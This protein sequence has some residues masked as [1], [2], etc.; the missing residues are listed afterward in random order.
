MHLCIYLFLTYARCYLNLTLH[1]SDLWLISATHCLSSATQ[2]VTHAWVC[3]HLHQSEWVIKSYCS[4]AVCTMQHIQNPWQGSKTAAVNETNMAQR[5]RRE[6]IIYLFIHY[7]SVTHHLYIH[8]YKKDDSSIPFNT[9]YRILHCIMLWFSQK[10][11]VQ[12]IQLCELIILN[13]GV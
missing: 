1:T 11:T 6:A 4:K 5:A 7:H 12:C 9:S 13:T 10:L 3:K 2:A 8:L